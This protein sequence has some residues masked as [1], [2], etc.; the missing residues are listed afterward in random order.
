[1]FD[2]GKTHR[3]P[4]LPLHHQAP[5]FHLL[6]Q[7][8]R[9]VHRDDLKTEPYTVI[10]FFASHFLPNDRA[11]LQSYTKAYT[12]LRA[13][14]IEVI[15]ISALNW[16]TLHHLSK[17]LSLPFKVLFDPCCRISKQYQCMLIP[18]FVTGRAV[19]ILNQQQ[20]IINAQKH[21][22]PEQVMAAIKKTSPV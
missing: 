9:I 14:H 1:M 17:T 22:T 6:D 15:A 19:Y 3:M 16:E 2:I 13:N 10:L 11:L 12:Q 20:Q 21:L 5:D 18:K 8:G 7:Y 4:L